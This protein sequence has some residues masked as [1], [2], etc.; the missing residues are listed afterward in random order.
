MFE[1]LKD[2]SQEKGD[3]LVEQLEHL[4]RDSERRIALMDRRDEIYQEL[5]AIYQTDP[6]D[7]ARLKVVET[8]LEALR[9]MVEITS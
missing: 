6:L 4:E 5:Q 8:K 3:Q 7:E 9:R 2:V 1:L